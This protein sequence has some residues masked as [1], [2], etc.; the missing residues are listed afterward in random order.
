MAI[1]L[2][3]INNWVEITEGNNTP[4]QIAKVDLRWKKTDGVHRFTNVDNTENFLG[5][6]TSFI[7]STDTVFAYERTFRLF[8]DDVNSVFNKSPLWSVQI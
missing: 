8:S 7:D 3:V 4:V 5:V 1:K 2:E 6:Y